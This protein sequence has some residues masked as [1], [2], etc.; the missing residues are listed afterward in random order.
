MRQSSGRNDARREIRGVRQGSRWRVK[1]VDA[2]GSER[3]N[4]FQ[5]KPDA[6][7]C[8]NGLPA[9]VQRGEYVD[10]RKSAETSGPVAEQWFATNQ[11]RKPKT[12]AGYRSLLDTVALP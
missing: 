4:S 1:W 6:Q 9:D 7:A 2:T 5:R 10:P 12:V 3:T 8:L 11:H